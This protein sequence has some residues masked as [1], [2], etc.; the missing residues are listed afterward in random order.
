MLPGWVYQSFIMKRVQYNQA[1][2]KIRMTQFL[3]MPLIVSVKTMV[4]R[5]SQIYL[6]IIFAAHLKKQRITSLV[7][8]LLALKKWELHFVL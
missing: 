3:E 4:N 7:C 6:R 2:G 5:C 1:S 8:T